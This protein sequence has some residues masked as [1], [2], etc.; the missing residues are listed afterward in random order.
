MNHNFQKPP[1]HQV[2]MQK[3]TEKKKYLKIIIA[4]SLSYFKSKYAKIIKNLH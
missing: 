2:E 4:Q 1:Y 3:I